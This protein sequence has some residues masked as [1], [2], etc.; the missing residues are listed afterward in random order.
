MLLY[1]Q[2]LEFTNILEVTDTFLRSNLSPGMG[3]LTEGILT[4]LALLVLM[5]PLH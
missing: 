1:S 3:T 4:G 5:L 2:P